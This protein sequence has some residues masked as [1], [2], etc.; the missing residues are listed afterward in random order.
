MSGDRPTKNLGF[1][2]GS[3][4]DPTAK[5]SSLIKTQNVSWKRE[6]GG[7]MFIKGRGRVHGIPSNDGVG[8]GHVVDA[9]KSLQCTQKALVGGS[10]LIR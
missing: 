6:R 8:R 4:N 10:D 1:G 2:D 7:R 9:P 5:K 3:D